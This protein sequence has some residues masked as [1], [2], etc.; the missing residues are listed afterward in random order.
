MDIKRIRWAPGAIADLEDICEFIS[1][2]SEHYA[3]LFAKR[4]IAV[5]ESIL[6]FP[7][8]GRA[9]AEYEDESIREKI[10][11]NYRIVYR[12]KDGCVEIVAICNSAK[13][14][15]DI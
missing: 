14:L 9:L 15:K 5:V 1:R 3:A 10:F 6:D 2:D 7:L 11:K 8:A 4:I 12:L 13:P